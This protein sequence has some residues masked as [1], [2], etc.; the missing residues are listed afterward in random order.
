MIIRVDNRVNDIT[1]L[2]VIS[3][4]KNNP[5]RLPAQSAGAVDYWIS[6]EE[7]NSTNERLGYDTKQSDGKAPV[8][9]IWECGLLF[10]YHPSLIHTSAE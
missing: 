8:L 7:D 9:K 4:M 2:L 1:V 6:T 10:H 3:A 5:Q